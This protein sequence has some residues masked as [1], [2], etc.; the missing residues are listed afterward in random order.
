[1]QR[2]GEH[3]P[4]CQTYADLIVWQQYP[5]MSQPAHSGQG[6]NIDD[7]MTTAVHDRILF[8]AWYPYLSAGFS[9]SVT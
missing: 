9:C 2:A 5:L 8:L 6:C 3:Q 7:T 1:M 4:A